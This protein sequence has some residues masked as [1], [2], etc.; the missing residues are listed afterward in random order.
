MK[1]STSILWVLLLCVTLLFSWCSEKNQE[2]KPIIPIWNAFS[3]YQTLFVLWDS[4]SAWYQLPIEKSY[5][6]LVEKK[7]LAL[8]YKIKVINGWESGDTSA[9]LKERTAR[10]TADARTGDIALVVI[11]GND[12]LQWLDTVAL[13]NNLKD[14]VLGL[15]WRGLLTII[16]GMQIPKNLGDRYRADFAAVYPRVARETDS[17]II[18]FILSWVAGNTDLNLADG[19]HPNETGQAIVADEVVEFLVEKGILVK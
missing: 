5:P 12:G 17:L 10:I 18:P 7:L 16:G 4:L 13:W 6:M 3:G 14:I 1:T 19:I 8:W 9:G 15:Q 2:H 11:G